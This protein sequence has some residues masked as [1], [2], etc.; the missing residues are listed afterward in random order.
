MSF[1][2]APSGFQLFLA[3]LPLFAKSGEGVMAYCTVSLRQKHALKW[4]KLYIR[5]PE[6]MRCKSGVTLF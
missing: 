2:A 5:L 1:L 6:Q 4:Q 3:T